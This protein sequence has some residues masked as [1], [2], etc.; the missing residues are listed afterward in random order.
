MNYE[1]SLKIGDILALD[2]D[3][4]NNQNFDTGK[5]FIRIVIELDPNRKLVCKTFRT[6]GNKLTNEITRCS[7]TPE[8]D[9]IITLIDSRGYHKI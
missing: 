9:N 3:N 2:F 8:W 7:I 4:D 1:H 6:F 5:Y